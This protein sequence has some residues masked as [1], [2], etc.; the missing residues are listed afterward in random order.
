MFLAK[1]I[2]RD[3]A[4]RPMSQITA[5]WCL[6]WAITT[7]MVCEGWKQWSRVGG[8]SSPCLD[9]NVKGMGKEEEEGKKRKRMKRGNNRLL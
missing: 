4:R 8:E 6:C 5:R 1:R 2:P 3:D 7:W 9:G